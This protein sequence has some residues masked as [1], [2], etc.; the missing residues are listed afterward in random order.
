LS[1]PVNF[2]P[3]GGEKALTENQNPVFICAMK[4]KAIGLTTTLFLLAATACFAASPM[5]GTWKLNAKKSKLAPGEGSNETVVY[6]PGMFGKMKCSVDGVDAKG[7]PTHSEWIGR[8]DGKD[9]PVKGDPH[10]DARSYT[11]VNDHTYDAVEKKN[12]KV[13]DKVRIVVSADGK[14][15][16]VTAWGTNKKGKKFKSVGV[17]NKQ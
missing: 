16:T 8:F 5:L 3:F 6:S 15:R 10:S 7:K 13:V 2:R 4:T 9:Y 1:K 17:Y 14:S 11:M 12:G